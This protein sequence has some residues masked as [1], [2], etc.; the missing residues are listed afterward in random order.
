MGGFYFSEYTMIANFSQNLRNLSFINGY[1]VIGNTGFY[2]SSRGLLG[3][4]T[5][6]KIMQD[7]HYDTKSIKC[8]D[9]SSY[10]EAKRKPSCLN[11]QHQIFPKDIWEL[12][13]D[14]GKL[15]RR[16]LYGTEEIRRPK[17]DFSE[18][19]PNIAHVVW[20]G[21]GPM[22]YLFY[23]SV[24]SLLYVVQVDTLY[25]HGNGP[26]SGQYW[27]SIKNHPRLKS[28]YREVGMVYGNKVGRK[29]LMS[30]VWRADFMVKYGG[31]YCDT[32]KCT[33][34]Y[35]DWHVM[36]SW[37]QWPDLCEWKCGLTHQNGRLF[38]DGF[39]GAFSW[40]KPFAFWLGFHWSLLLRVQF[41]ITQHQF[42]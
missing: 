31:I 39:S 34:S 18:L 41:T 32:G 42:K 38:A 12:N 5:I 8:A 1:N 7:K 30:D 16:V 15:A 13:D 4:F 9:K 2:M 27:D 20:I 10:V 37:Q 19:A 21:G 35:V 14:F 17:Q 6:D 33:W 28:I 40:M 36:C 25:I 29:S 22:E 11:S 3:K 26:P 24:L 23:L